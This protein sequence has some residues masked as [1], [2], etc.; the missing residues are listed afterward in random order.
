MQPLTITIE[1]AVGIHPFKPVPID[2][3]I[4]VDLG[5]WDQLPRRGEVVTFRSHDLTAD[6]R[7]KYR[8][9][10]PARGIARVWFTDATIERGRK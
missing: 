9:R 6:V 8:R 7:V 2:V 4:D 10:Y 3:V 5:M 1:P